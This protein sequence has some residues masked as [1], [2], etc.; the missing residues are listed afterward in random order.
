[1]LWTSYYNCSPF[2]YY[3]WM[4]VCEEN[5]KGLFASLEGKGGELFNNFE[6]EDSLLPRME[7]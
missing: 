5:T 3:N 6:R 1:M 2:F 7:V 4:V